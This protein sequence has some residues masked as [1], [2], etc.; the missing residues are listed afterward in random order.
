METRYDLLLCDADDTLFD[1]SKASARAF[2]VMCR[3]NDIPDTPE[4]YQTYHTINSALWHAFD[5][6]E[7]TKEFITV[8]RYVRLLQA[9]SLNRSAEKCNQDYLSALGESVF[10]LPDAEAVCRTLDND[11]GRGDRQS[12]LLSAMVKQ[13][14]KITAKNIV[15]IYNSLKHAWRSSLSGVEQAKLLTQALWLRGAK[16]ERIGVPFE[17]YWHYGKTKGGTSGV[18][19]DLEDNRRM[20]LDALGMKDTRPADEAAE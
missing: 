8:E 1:F 18:M 9:L 12:K 11:F 10:P 15:D 19:A 20:L 6:G 16:V 3:E 14:K 5:Q 17:G 13:T 4:V 7:V 2:S